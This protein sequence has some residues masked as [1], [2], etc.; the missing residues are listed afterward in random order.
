[1]TWALLGPQISVPW[2]SPQIGPSFGSWFCAIGLGR[3]AER[4]SARALV[5]RPY[6]KVFCKARGPIMG[7]SARIKPQPET[8]AHNVWPILGGRH[9]RVKTCHPMCASA[10]MTDPRHTD[11]DQLKAL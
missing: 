4:F 2:G 10:V 5:L 1:M 9:R 6:A 11:L 8:A 7:A 3:L